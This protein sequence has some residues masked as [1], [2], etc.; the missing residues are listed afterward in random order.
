MRIEGILTL[1]LAGLAV[2]A[3]EKE[4]PGPMVPAAGTTQAIDK[5]IMDLTNA[6]C[7]R[8]QRCKNIGPNAKYQNREHC[9]N[10]E[11]GESR[12]KLQGCT[13]GV[14]QQDMRQCLT[15]I[16][17]QDCSGMFSGVGEEK[18]CGMDDLCD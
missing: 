4:K 8:Q 11:G 6:R 13:H 18:S 16:E 3:C 12:D 10:V 5:A 2:L 14:D 9:M 15:A 17:N 7:D 1:C